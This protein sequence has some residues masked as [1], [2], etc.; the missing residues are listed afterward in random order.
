VAVNSRGILSKTRNF[1]RLYVH[2]CGI[3]QV[4]NAYHVWTGISL[5]SAC[6]SKNVWLQKFRGR[7]DTRLYPNLYTFLL[8]SSSIGK[9]TAVN[10]ALG[11]IKSNPYINIY[12]GELTA[13][14]LKDNLRKPR[15]INGQI[16]SDGSMYLVTPE[17]A[18]SIGAGPLADRFV[19]FMTDI[20]GCSPV[21]FREGTRMHGTH[22]IEEPCV[23]WMGGS[24]LEWLMDSIPPD[25]IISGF[26][27]RVIS[28]Y[29][30][31]DL[32]NRVTFPVVP[33]DYAEVRE[34][35]IWRINSMCELARGEYV[36]TAEAEALEHEW[37]MTR[38][39]PTDKA[40]IPIWKREHDHVLKLCMLFAAADTIFWQVPPPALVITAKHMLQA[41]NHMLLVRSN[42]DRIMNFAMVSNETKYLATVQDKI[43]QA[44]SIQRSVLMRAVSC[45]GVS[46]RMLDEC[47]ATLMES[48]LIEVK[49]QGAGGAIFYIWKK[50]K[51]FLGGI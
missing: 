28:V 42:V 46:K 50:S 5:L 9:D 47:L 48:G 2:H 40:L 30:E 18:N 45:R 36:R 4:P 11:L 7:P 25:A 34:H 26:F 19:K 38:P 10:I 21:P 1:I 6:L 41:Q 3:S 23:V 14:S 44:K 33:P 17:L 49:M 27:A 51:H 39:E 35:L 13:P 15:N 8:G 12:R 20:Y 43:F 16:V 24:T 37:Y 31:D 32:S 22:E 29:A